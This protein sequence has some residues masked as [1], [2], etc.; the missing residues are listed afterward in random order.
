MKSLNKAFRSL[1]VGSYFIVN[2]AAVA[3]CHRCFL[4][5]A[6][7]IAARP[8]KDASKTEREVETVWCPRKTG[9]VARLNKIPALES[10]C[11]LRLRRFR[12]VLVQTG[13]FASSKV[14]TKRRRLQWASSVKKVGIKFGIKE[15][16]V[17]KVPLWTK[18]RYLCSNQ[19]HRT[20]LKGNIHPHQQYVLP[21]Y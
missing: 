17:P 16:R 3:T 14:Y 9:L 20:F 10:I 12:L 7:H 1:P 13:A 15:D 8:R 2:Q 19:K 4:W 5:V 21:W 18:K 6:P 11:F